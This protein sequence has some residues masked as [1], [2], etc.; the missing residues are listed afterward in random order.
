MATSQSIV[1]LPS[2]LSHSFPVYWTWRKYADSRILVGG[3]P[4]R[5]N[6]YQVNSSLPTPTTTTAGPGNSPTATN[7]PSVVPAA[8]GFTYIGCYTE[9]TNGRALSGLANPA[10]G[11]TLTV[12][13]CAAACKGFAFMGL[14]YSGECYCGNT[15]V[16][17][18]SLAPGSTPADTQCV[19]PSQ[20]SLLLTSGTTGSGTWLTECV[21]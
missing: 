21:H 10:G 19:S 3:G 14:E 8:D 9:G 20:T 13:L 15:I 12:S 16:G 18:N 6:M 2:L 11:S 7:G 4:N 17:S 5:L 1:Y